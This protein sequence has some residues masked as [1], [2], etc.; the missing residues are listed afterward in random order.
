MP[1]EGQILAADIGGTH[2]RFLFGSAS[3]AGT[4][5]GEALDLV[6]RDAGG[7]EGLLAGALERLGLQP[8]AAVE[9]V[10]AMAGPVRDG[11]AS[12]TNLSWKADAATL[13]RRFGFRHLSFINDLEA[14]ARALAEHPPADAAVLRAGGGGAGRSVVISVGTGLGAAYWSGAGHELQVE[15]SEA[16][17]VGFAPTEAW[18]W[19]LLQALQQRHGE[20]VSWERVV[21]GAG[22]AFLDAHLR[23]GEPGTPAE[24]AHRAA[25]GDTPALEALERFSRLLGVFAGDL[26]LAAPASGVWLTGG[27]L[28]GLGPLFDSSAFLEGFDAK[29]RLSPVPAATPVRR[30]DDGTLGVRGAWL[31]ARHQANRRALWANP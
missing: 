9:A 8:P 26:V 28:A 14:A 25:A 12:L 6:T 7:M 10:F 11:Q 24:V 22:L 30:T 1:P 31:T 5:A 23:R 20:H 15:S 4:P 2:A 3:H 16:G 29:G 27:V 18:Q 19:D 13:K 21:S 17:H